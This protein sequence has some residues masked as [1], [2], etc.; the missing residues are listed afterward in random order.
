MIRFGRRKQQSRDQQPPVS[1]DPDT[2]D[3][4]LDDLLRALGKAARKQGKPRPTSNA[5]T[6]RGRTETGGSA[7]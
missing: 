1:R 3:E 6:N 7:S 4:T 5:T 2:D